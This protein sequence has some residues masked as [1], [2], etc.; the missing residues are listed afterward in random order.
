MNIGGNTLDGRYFLG[1]MDEVRA[2]NRALSD[3][4]V[5]A[6]A[7]AGGYDSWAA[8]LPA[9]S[10][11]P[12]SDPDAD[13]QVNLLEYAFDTNPLAQNG[14]AF[15]IIRAGDDSVWLSYPRRT[16]FSG[17]EYAVLKSDDLLTWTPLP[18]G[19]VQE[20]TQPVP[21]RPLE[22]VLARVVEV[23][24]GAFFRLHVQSTQP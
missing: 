4:E 2:Y 6:L 17:L 8:T 21:G 13:G 5:A 19:Y 14:S 16:G 22:I 9:S 20:T 7:A 24:E 10:A 11:S 1:Q 3:A 12:M 18:D 15:T 23:S